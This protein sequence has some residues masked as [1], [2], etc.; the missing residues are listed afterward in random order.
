[1]EVNQSHFKWLDQG[2]QSNRTFIFA[3]IGGAGQI[4]FDIFTG[5]IGNHQFTSDP[6]NY[7]VVS[8]NLE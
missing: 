2:D 5:A 7:I 8:G 6:L 4:F 1:M 3:C